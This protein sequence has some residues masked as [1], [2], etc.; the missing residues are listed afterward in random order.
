MYERVRVI[1]ELGQALLDDF[2]GLAAQLVAAAKGSAVKLVNLVI[3]YL[4]GN[5]DESN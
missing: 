3:R 2:D 1:R 4:P 5:E